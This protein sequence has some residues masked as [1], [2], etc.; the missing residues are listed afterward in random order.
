MSRLKRFKA[1]FVR[2]TGYYPSLTKMFAIGYVN[3]LKFFILPDCSFKVS[4]KPSKFN[5]DVCLVIVMSA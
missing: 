2:D 5:V 1:F 4:V 3:I